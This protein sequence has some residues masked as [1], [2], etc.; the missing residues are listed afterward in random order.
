MSNPR[1][2]VL[3]G[4]H[5]SGKTGLLE[6]LVRRYSRAG[7]AVGVIKRA[8]RPLQFD[9]AGKD[10]ARFLNAG[11]RR[12][13]TQGP[14]LVYTQT[15]EAQPASLPALVREFKTG[16]ECWL[17]ESFEPESL[18]WL[19][20][21]R[22]GQPAPSIDRHCLATVGDRPP[23]SRLPHFRLE[24]PAALARF[25]SPLLLSSGSTGD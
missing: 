18:P 22:S 11:C 13:V 19:R 17:V 23:D 24:R 15:V 14:G 4:P 10:S 20:V 12:V 16:I 5:N 8:A 6:Y 9:P 7:C 3:V 2:V 25:L 21:A 1:I